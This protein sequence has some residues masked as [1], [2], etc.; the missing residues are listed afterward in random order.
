MN[1]ISQLQPD[2]ICKGTDYRPPDGKPM[3]EKVIVEEYGGRV[4]FID[5][6]PGKSTTS[7]SERSGMQN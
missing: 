7:I 4:E 6:L 1:A 5:L 3:P 2:V